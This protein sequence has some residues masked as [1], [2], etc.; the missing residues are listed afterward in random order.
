[1]LSLAIVKKEEQTAITWD[2]TKNTH[3]STLI[4]RSAKRSMI[5]NNDSDLSPKTTTMTLFGSWARV[6]FA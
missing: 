5:D 1:M 2:K 3:Y 4:F 6:S